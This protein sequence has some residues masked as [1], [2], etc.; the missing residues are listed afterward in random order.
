M[1]SKSQYRTLSGLSRMFYRDWCDSGC[2]G[3]SVQACL[4]NA[5]AR[6]KL[7]SEL[8]R[9]LYERC[10]NPALVANGKLFALENHITGTLQAK[11]VC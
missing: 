2:P 5:C 10:F 11:S 3:A 6:L 9:R 4:R 7:P 8:G 1:V